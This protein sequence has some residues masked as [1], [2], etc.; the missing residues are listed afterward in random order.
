MTLKE[1][2]PKLA[3]LLKDPS[4]RRGIAIL[5]IC[6]A[7]FILLA[8]LG[9]LRGRGRADADETDSSVVPQ[10]SDAAP[11]KDMDDNSM[12]SQH[13]TARAFQDA[14]RPGAESMWNESEPVTGAPTL[15]TEE[16]R[17]QEEERRRTATTGTGAGP[18]DGY[19]FF[20]VKTASETATPPPQPS[21]PSRSSGT[22][23]AR[24][25]EETLAESDAY[26]R[27]RGIDP[28]TGLPLPKEE[29]KKTDEPAE[30][31][32]QPEET[33]PAVPIRRSGGISS[34]DGESSSL[35][36]LDGRD[37]FIRE[38]ASHPYR[39]MFIR[40]QKVQAGDRVTLRLL[41]DLPVG[42][43]LIPCNT[44]L[45]ATVSISGRLEL[46]VTSFEMNGKLY[47]MAYSA[48]DNDGGMGLYCPQT[49]ANRK[50]KEGAAQGGDLVSSALQSGITGMAGRVVA[51]GT[52]MIRSS[53]GSVAVNLVSG[54]EFYI[55]QDKKN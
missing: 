23:R 43:I 37:E 2:F 50:N 4:S 34:L 18:D 12:I 44:H 46:K 31:T 30:Q 17:R 6:T 1:R 42:G 9:S 29:E 32:V 35:D 15:N 51:A 26:L 49:N 11:G 24:T 45:M 53:T 13:R 41:E 25:P 3:D 33:M 10:F 36:N 48:Y 16:A 7:G 20:G 40:S 19:A 39:V 8:A 22:R 47:S 21:A 27:S 38:D 5:C 14:R 28:A 54:Y 55:M 52:S